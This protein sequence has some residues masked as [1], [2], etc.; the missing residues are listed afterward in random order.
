MKRGEIWWASLPKPRA[1]EPGYRRPVLIVQADEFNRSNINTVL[2]AAM[3]SNVNL[4]AA[5]G[6]VQLSGRASGLRKPSVVNVSQLIT[7]DYPSLER[8]ETISV[9]G[10]TG[11]HNYCITARGERLSCVSSRGMLIDPHTLHV[12]WRSGS[13]GYLRGL[14]VGPDQVFVGES[15]QAG[16][17]LRASGVSGLWVVDRRTWQAVDYIVLGPYGV[18][19]EV[20]LIDEVDEAHHGHRFRGSDRLRSDEPWQQQVTARLA[21]SQRL[22]ELVCNGPF[23]LV[24]GAPQVA[25]NGWWQSPQELCLMLTRDSQPEEIGLQYDFR[26][27]AEG[28]HCGVVLGC[29]SHGA[30]PSLRDTDMDVIVATQSGEDTVSLAHWQH[31]GSAWNRQAVLA[32]VAGLSG[33]LRVHRDGAAVAVH[34]GAEA[35]RVASLPFDLLSRVDLPWGI[36]WQGTRVMPECQ[37]HQTDVLTRAAPSGSINMQ[38][39]GFFRFRCYLTRFRGSR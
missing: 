18:V 9:P 17:H 36:R 24:I 11:I 34:A 26:E 12:Y 13:A 4:A 33:V 37:P 28:G 16:R 29:G 38:I 39:T 7:L 20:R 30:S 27:Q 5:P 15:P 19:N 32:E 6:N 10:C 21:G 23:D 8:R 22:T 14:A 31:D 2:A 1:S 35:Q 3:T 25:D